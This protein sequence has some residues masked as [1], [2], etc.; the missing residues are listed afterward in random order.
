MVTSDANAFWALKS[1]KI[2]AGMI[3]HYLYAARNMVRSLK[4]C[5]SNGGYGFNYVALNFSNPSV[6]FLRDV[7]VR[8]ALA[9]AVNQSQIIQ[10]AFHGL[11]VPGFN[12][13]PTSPDTYLSQKMK[14]LVSDPKLAYDPNRAKLLLTEAGWL[15]GKDGIRDRDGKELKFTMMVPDTSQTLVAVAELLKAGWQSI[16]VD[17]RLRMVP[18]NLEVAKMHPGGKWDAA[19]I[20]WSYNP[21]YYPSGD[22]LFN[23]GG[24]SNYGGY[25]NIHM[26]QLIRASADEEGARALHQYEDY[27]YEQQ[28][29]IFLPYPEYI[30]KYA[31]YL[32]HAKLMEGLYSVD[33]VPKHDFR[34]NKRFR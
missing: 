13:V 22:G 4:T 21:D 29:V 11:G 3:P 12:P 10:I 33:C 17:L 25:S 20:V 18:F 34:S 24:G 30:V 5:V 9:L 31:S 23:T 14:K 7:Q 32:S 28:P 26:D 16:G 6:A 8:Q 1:G 27:A 19:M 15:P 2:Q